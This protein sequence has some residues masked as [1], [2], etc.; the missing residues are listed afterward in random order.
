MIVVRSRNWTEADVCAILLIK[1]ASNKNV[2][3]RPPPLAG[4]EISPGIEL[5]GAEHANTLRRNEPRP[6]TLPAF[7][8]L[9]P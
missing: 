8:L 9:R 5:Y 4:P 7:V 3:A 6:F 1:P 2:R